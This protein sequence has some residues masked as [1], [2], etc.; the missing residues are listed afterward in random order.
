MRD[1][2]FDNIVVDSHVFRVH[3]YLSDEEK[4]V[5]GDEGLWAFN[6]F[7]NVFPKHGNDV[8]KLVR[9]VLVKDTEV[10]ERVEWAL[11]VALVLEVHLEGVD[12][13]HDIE[14]VAQAW[15][16]FVFRVH[17]LADSGRFGRVR[18]LGHHVVLG[19]LLL[20]HSNLLLL[21]LLLLLKEQSLLVFDLLGGLG[22]HWLLDIRDVIQNFIGHHVGAHGI[23]SADHV[24]AAVHHHIAALDEALLL[25]E[26]AVVVLRNEV[27]LEVHFW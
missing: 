10:V 22:H 1:K 23:I 9:V 21:K 2:A 25:D 3:E 27:L 6:A 12:H 7:D 19:L 5:L 14:V 18:L 13:G 4:R 24:I 11:P 17:F 15:Q 16:I 8:V 20:D 26:R